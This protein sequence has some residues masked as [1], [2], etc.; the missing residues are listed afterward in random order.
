VD[1]THG[2]AKLSPAGMTWLLS[3]E[4]QAKQDKK[5]QK[6]KKVH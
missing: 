5:S 4:Q 6:K 3:L 1:G 2:A